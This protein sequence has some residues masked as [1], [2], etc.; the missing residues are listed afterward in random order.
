[1]PAQQKVRTYSQLAE[2]AVNLAEIGTDTFAAIRLPE[3]VSV[4]KVDLQV[5]EVA[6]TGAL[7][8][9]G[10]GD[11]QDAIGNDLDIATSGNVTPN[12]CFTTSSVC[13]ITLTASQ[14]CSKGKVILRVDYYLPSEKVFEFA[15]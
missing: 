1:M 9:I 15:E 5:V 10:L 4:M 11:T 2:V 7:I 14:A 8:D 13:D 3:N 6:D 12:A